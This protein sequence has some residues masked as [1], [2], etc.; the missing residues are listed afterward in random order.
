[1]GQKK[2]S[3][4][5]IRRFLTGRNCGGWFHHKKQKPFVMV[6]VKRLREPIEKET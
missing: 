3:G 6:Y 5:W 2:Q 1:M 4:G